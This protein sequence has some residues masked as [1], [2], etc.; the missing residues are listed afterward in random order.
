MVL[1]QAC[2]AENPGYNARM[3][4]RRSQPTDGRWLDIDEVRL[5]ADL[6]LMHA[7]VNELHACIASLKHRHNE[8][9][10]CKY[11]DAPV[12]DE[13]IEKVDEIYLWFVKLKNERERGLRRA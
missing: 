7:K 1:N 6:R 8:A 11:A 5:V 13:D 4:P 10:I 12:L 3:H 2:T 9:D